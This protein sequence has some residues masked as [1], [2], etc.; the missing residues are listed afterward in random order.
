MKKILYL[1]FWA[2]GLLTASSCSD[3]LDT[4]SP[5]VLDVDFVFS[6][7]DNTRAAMY[8]VY[9]AWRAVAS[10]HVFGDGLYY[11]ADVCGSDIERHPEAFS[12]QPGRHYP[13][14]LYQNGTFTSSYGLLS[15]LTETGAYAQLYELVGKSN[16]V[17]N[18]LKES[19]SYEEFMNGTSSEL[20]QLYG[21]AVA[22]RAIAYRELIRYFGDVPFQLKSGQSATQLAPRDSIYDYINN[23]LI[24]VEPLM[25][26]VGET[27]VMEKNIFSRTFVQGLIGRISL[28]AAGYQTRRTDLG[29]DFYKK[30]NGESVSLEQ[31]G[32]PNNNADG[33]VYARRSDWKDLYNTAKTY[34]KM[35]ID[36]SGS[37][38]FIQRTLVRQVAE[39]KTLKIPIST[40]SNR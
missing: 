40:S 23:D 20:G 22:A 8:G 11:A 1:F 17:I 26:R 5:S 7:V 39:D 25:Y 33:A 19:A 38:K 29:A 35:V 27:A 10:S 2:G 9:E 21:E 31:L 16:A 4:K 32:M 3:Y 34:F 6:D 14:C 12:N 24:S 30:G 18:A 15:Y 28:D 36:N 13:E 37:A